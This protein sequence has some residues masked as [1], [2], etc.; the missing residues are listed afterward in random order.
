[1]KT[2]RLL[3]LASLFAIA[4]CSP[5]KPWVKPYERQNIADE[6]MSFDRDPVASSYLHHVYDAREAARGGDG[7][8]GG[9][10]GCN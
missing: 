10:C 2:Q 7:A 9:G 5:I 3:L 8:S 6:I 4:A 1:M